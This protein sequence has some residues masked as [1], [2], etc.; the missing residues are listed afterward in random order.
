[1]VYH[2]TAPSATGN[3]E[4]FLNDLPKDHY[5]LAE[6]A[7]HAQSVGQR[8]KRD[9][10]F[11]EVENRRLHG[12]AAVLHKV[13]HLLSWQAGKLTEYQNIRT[14]LTTVAGLNNCCLSL[15][16]ST[17]FLKMDMPK[18]GSLIGCFEDALH[19][20]SLV[21]LAPPPALG[22]SLFAAFSLAPTFRFIGITL[23]LTLL[24]VVITGVLENILDDILHR[25][26]IYATVI[27]FEL[28]LLAS[29]WFVVG[30]P[31]WTDQFLQWL[32]FVL[33]QITVAVPVVETL[34][35]NPSVDRKKAYL[36]VAL[37]MTILTAVVGV[38]AALSQ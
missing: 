11:G 23:S 13:K 4:A 38:I 21:S 15:G 19:N 12:R 6:I 31:Q 10:H 37:I 14:L 2:T 18:D 33:L 3:N 27:T 34:A 22:A 16:Q 32:G 9:R 29:L 30:V 17:I 24:T 26:A 8:V 28:A 7:L 35:N 20:T 5:Y 1:M 25:V 36:I